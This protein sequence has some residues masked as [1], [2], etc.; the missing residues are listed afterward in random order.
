MRG[1]RVT[2]SGFVENTILV[3]FYLN[4]LLWGYKYDSPALLRFSFLGPVKT[5]CILTTKSY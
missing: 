5:K 2:S 1:I 4:I 3:F